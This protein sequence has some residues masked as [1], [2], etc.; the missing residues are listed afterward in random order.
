MAASSNFLLLALSTEWL[1]HTLKVSVTSDIPC[2]LTLNYR[3]RPPGRH[4]R[5]KFKRGMPLHGDPHWDFKETTPIEQDEA[6]DTYSHRFY[7]PWPEGPIK[8]WFQFTGTVNEIKSPSVSPFF[9]HTDQEEFMQVI[10]LGILGETQVLSGNVKFQAGDNITI[11]R[12]DPNQ[13]FKFSAPIPPGVHHF[14][15]DDGPLVEVVGG[16]TGDSGWQTLDLSP[17][18]PAT[19]T[20]VILFAHLALEDGSGNY[21]ATLKFRKKATDPA[22]MTT[23]RVAKTRGEIPGGG[24]S[25]TFILALDANQCIERRRMC[26]TGPDF[27]QVSYHEGILGYIT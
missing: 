5:I 14:W 7:W 21:W 16:A 13:S 23:L 22:V 18:L 20:F 8:Y 15:L 12:D 9:S 11:Q 1:D 17:W 19:A 10:S 24:G 4:D 2:H 27:T 26:G 6:G 25:Q 3:E